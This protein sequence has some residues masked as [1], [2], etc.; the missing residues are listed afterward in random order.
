MDLL[1]FKALPFIARIRLGV[2]VLRAKSI[3][4]WRQLEGRSAK[5][6]LIDLCGQ[7]AYDVVWDPLLVGKF[8]DV[9]EDVSAV[10]FWKKLALRG[11]SRSSSGDEVLA[12]YKG[13][14]AELANR[15]GEAIIKLGCEIRLNSGATAV[16]SDEGH[17]TGVQV[18]SEFISADN[19]RLSTALPISAG[20]LEGVADDD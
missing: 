3:K 12:Y 10:W 7:K 11:G 6:W 14:F 20:L 15:L 19:V 1:R 13:G 8:G 17:A 5:E 9:A 16:T 2:A 4:D 18:G